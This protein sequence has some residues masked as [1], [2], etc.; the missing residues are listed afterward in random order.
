MEGLTRHQRKVHSS[1][2]DFRCGQCDAAFAY[3]YDLSRHMRRSHRLQPTTTTSRVEEG[4][5]VYLCHPSSEAAALLPTDPFLPLDRV[6]GSKVHGE[7]GGDVVCFTLSHPAVSSPPEESS[8]SSS[9]TLVEPADEARATAEDYGEYSQ[10]Q[11]I[12]IE[13]LSYNSILGQ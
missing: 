7:S 11:T 3:N 12:Q 2:K 10:Y 5:T 6:V 4:E 9:G 1:H 8:V 13:G